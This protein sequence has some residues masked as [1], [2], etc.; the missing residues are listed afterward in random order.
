MKLDCGL[1]IYSNHDPL[2]LIY[3]KDC[4]GPAMERRR[5]TDIR[6][7]L[8]NRECT[9]P[10]IVYAIAMDVGKP[11]HEHLLSEMK[12]LFGI[13]IFEKGK[14]GNEP[15][16]SQ[17]HIHQVSCH[18]GWSPPEVYQILSGTA[19][20]YM[21]ETADIHP[22]RCFAVQAGPGDIVIVPPNWA[23]AT[24]STD[25]E[26]PLIF[27]AWCDREYSFLYDAIR[28]KN[29]LAWRAVFDEKNIL[30]WQNNSS[31]LF[32]DLIIKQP[33]N[34]FNKF[35]IETKIPLYHQFENDP[36]RF[37]FVSKPALKEE[38]WENFVP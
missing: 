36:D 34:Y 8:L 25:P 4:F 26:N 20:V 7:S 5:L 13:V 9:G 16:R 38:T 30:R 11:V 14:L 2:G 15:V 29:G 31:Y 12:L 27:C 32:S 10:E 17:G 28:S 24:I 37:S 21:Q 18:S 6:K 35:G 33:G 19:T 23:H 1:D 3:G 22:G